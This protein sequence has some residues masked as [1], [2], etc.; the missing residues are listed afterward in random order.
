[1]SI[2]ERGQQSDMGADGL[3]VHVDEVPEQILCRDVAARIEA[4]RGKI[5]AHGPVQ[6]AE[7]F[8]LKKAL[9]IEED[10]AKI[11]PAFI[12]NELPFDDYTKTYQ[13]GF[14]KNMCLAWFCYEKKM[15]SNFRGFV[16]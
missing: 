4:L 14:G 8:L 16:T 13:V 2:K 10:L 7:Y 11:L 15:G 3:G 1:M 5:K 12:E 6:D 9:R